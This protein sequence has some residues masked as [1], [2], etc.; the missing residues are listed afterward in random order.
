MM[1]A[2]QMHTQHVSGTDQ[3]L[4]KYSCCMVA[5]TYMCSSCACRDE[6]YALS[7][8]DPSAQM[9][10]ATQVLQQDRDQL[11]SPELAGKHTVQRPVEAFLHNN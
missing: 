5:L 3:T 10:S 7:V 11:D 9:V 2:A 6:V 1:T 8:F 4:F